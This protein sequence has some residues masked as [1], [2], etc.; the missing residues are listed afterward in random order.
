MIILTLEI[1]H[2]LDVTRIPNMKDMVYGLY[3]FGGPFV[4]FL[5]T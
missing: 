1:P 3:Q 5:H 2:Y 4:D